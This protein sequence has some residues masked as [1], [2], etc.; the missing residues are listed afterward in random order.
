VVEPDSLFARAIE[1]AGSVARGALVAQ[2]MV[3][4]AVDEGTESTLP[5]GLALELS[6]FE[7]VFNTSDSQT[8]IASFREHGPGKAS[9]VGE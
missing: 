5:D 4:R 2:R 1:L 8:G 9:F 7:H 3:K 6:L